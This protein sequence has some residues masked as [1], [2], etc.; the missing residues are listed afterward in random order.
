[1]LKV[2]NCTEKSAMCLYFPKEIEM[3]S[4]SKLASK[5]NKETMINMRCLVGG[6]HNVLLA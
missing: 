3:I 4:S 2:P 1:M 5:R 6:A